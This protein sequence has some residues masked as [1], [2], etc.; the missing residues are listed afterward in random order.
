M[1]AVKDGDWVPPPGWKRLLTWH[2]H[3]ERFDEHGLSLH[4]LRSV[5][6]LREALEALVRAAWKKEH[7]DQQ[8]PRGFLSSEIDIRVFAVTDGCGAL[9]LCVRDDG[10]GGVA[11]PSFVEAATTR[12]FDFAHLVQQSNG[13]IPDLPDDVRAA[14][15]KV[16]RFTSSLGT[17]ERIELVPG[18]A[19]VRAPVV[20]IDR[21]FTQQISSRVGGRR[22]ADKTRQPAE[23]RLSGRAFMVN[24]D[25][26]RC[27]MTTATGAVAV[28][29]PESGMKAAAAALYVNDSHRLYVRGIATFDT[30]GRMYKIGDVSNVSALPVD[31]LEKWTDPCDAMF[32]YLAVAAPH[33]LVRMITDG[34]LRNADMAFA[35]DHLGSAPVEIAADVLIDLLKHD[36]IVVREAAIRGLSHF[37]EEERVRAALEAVLQNEGEDALI[38]EIAGE[39]L[40]S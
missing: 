17:K 19:G 10:R 8:L 27:V 28:Y 23:V 14:A 7:K 1:K 18:S 2:F 29:L 30:E 5:G 15:V 25:E 26:R 20:V 13:P 32:E 36:H 6:A 3:G 34:G 24:N 12:V 39:A 31:V 21:E 37:M 9:P 35:A 11:P 33:Q 4:D 38:R 22:R 40:G 16:K